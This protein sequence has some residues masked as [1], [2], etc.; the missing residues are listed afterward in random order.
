MIEER[1]VLHRLP[2][3]RMNQAVI[4]K[5]NII[6]FAL[7]CAL[8]YWDQFLRITNSS[9]ACFLSAFNIFIYPGFFYYFANK[10]RALNQTQMDYQKSEKKNSLCR[11]PSYK[12]KAMIGLV[13]GIFGFIALLSLTSIMFYQILI[14]QNPCLFYTRDPP[15][16]I[17]GQ[18]DQNHYDFVNEVFNMK[19]FV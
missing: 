13:Y 15:T 10:Q 1:V 18:N 17:S 9:I 19:S 2:Y 7:T 12:Q 14:Y 3:M 8:A 6:M 4:S 5:V 11:N 16:L